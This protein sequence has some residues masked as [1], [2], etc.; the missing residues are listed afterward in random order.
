MLVP[1]NLFLIMHLKTIKYVIVQDKIVLCMYA[2]NTYI[3]YK[4]IKKKLTNK[5]QFFL[6]SIKLD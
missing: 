1:E 5:L 4:K 2:Y 6:F 3:D